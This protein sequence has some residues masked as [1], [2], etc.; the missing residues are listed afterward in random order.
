MRKP[1]REHVL[2]FT[3]ATGI[4]AAMVMVYY[5]LIH[6]N[7]TTV[8]LSLLLAILY[9]SATWGLVVSIFM[10]VL[11]AL[12]FNF[13][14]LPPYLTF[15]IA[16]PQNWVAF[17]AFLI[18]AIGAS[19][20][21]DY[22]REEARDAN[23]RRREVERLYAFTQQLLLSGNMGELLNTVPRRLVESF[24]VQDAALFLASKNE[25]YRFGADIRH[26]DSDRLKAVMAR[27]EPVVD[28]DANLCFV[29][30]R[31]GARPVGSV[32]ISGGSLSRQTLEAVG[33]LIAIA[34]ER[35][36][37]LEALGKAEAAREEEKLR[38][39]LLDSVTHELRTPLTSIKGAVTSLLSQPELTE[40]HRHELLTVIDEE[41]NRLNRLIEEALEMARLDAGEF[42][43]NKQSTPIDKVIEAAREAMKVCLANHPVEVRLPQQLPSVPMDFE[44]IKEVLA[45]LLENAAKY[46][47]AGAPIIISS[48]VA[49]GYLVTSV[50]DRGA[51]I[52]ALEQSLIFD[53][54]YRGKDLRYRV[55]GT[56]MG[57][58]ICKAIVEA[59]GGKIGVTSQIGSGSVFQFSLPIAG[60][61]SEAGRP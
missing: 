22:A 29:P 33:T 31:M 39:A 5:K 57:L 42:E 50:A 7:P 60:G 32:G 25:I 52:D 54:F 13:F 37:A 55:Q 21:S 44:R 6:V 48:E 28:A 53:K 15:T 61:T 10:S 46:S 2:G 34:V 59:H 43:L 36:G 1:S 3:V 47:P 14:F 38:T 12:A 19:R 30:V 11:A 27:G 8:A 51:G 16:D 49:H 41:S 23:R 35:F 9:V 20:L 56:G 4:V 45:H 40:A 17:A 26:L 24:G 18:S 58:A